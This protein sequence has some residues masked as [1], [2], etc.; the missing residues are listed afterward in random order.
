M[1]KAWFITGA[2]RGMGRLLV[3][4]ALERRD[5]VA[6]TLRHPVDLDDLADR[7]GTQFVGFVANPW[8]PP[9]GT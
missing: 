6:A 9:G 5:T 4:Q 7:Y 1:T 3:E 8:M 2:S